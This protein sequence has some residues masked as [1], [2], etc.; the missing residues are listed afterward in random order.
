MTHVVITGTG[1]YTPEHAIDNAAL[2][3]AF[4][5]WVDAENEQHA[6]AIARGEREP[7]AH[8]AASLSKSLRY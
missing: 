7:L 4:N 2:V 3:A 8:P 1:L 6:E 5:T